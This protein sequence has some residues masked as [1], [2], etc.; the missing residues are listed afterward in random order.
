[1]SIPN[2]RSLAALVASAA[3][4]LSLG[5]ND[6]APPA[7][8]RAPA[9]EGAAVPGGAD[10]DRSRSALLGFDH[11][12]PVAAFFFLALS[13][14]IS[15]TAGGF[16][17]PLEAGDA[18]GASSAALGDLDGDGFVEVAV[19]ARG[20]GVE[21][22][23]VWI[24]SLNTDSTVRWERLITQST[25]GFGGT[26]PDYATFGRSLAA[27]GD[28]DGDGVTDLAVGASG[29]LGLPGSVWVLFLDS[30]GTVKREQEISQ[31]TGGFGGSLDGNDRFG[32]SLAALGDVDGDGSTELAVGAHLDDDGG[33][34]RGAVWLLSLGA[35]G[36]VVAERKLSSTQGGLDADLTDGYYLGISVAAPGDLNG[37]GVPDLAVGSMEETVWVLLLDRDLTIRHHQPIA[38]GTGRFH[39][40]LDLWDRFGHGLAA[41]G[42]LDGD[43]VPDLLA[44]APGDDDCGQDGGALWLLY[45]TREGAVSWSV[46]YSCSQA[47]F[48]KEPGS[49]EI[50]LGMLGDVNHDGLSEIGVGSSAEGDNQGALWVLYGLRFCDGD[51]DDVCLFGQD[52]CVEME[53]RTGV[54]DER[55][56]F[57]PLPVAQDPTGAA[58]DPIATPLTVA[59][60]APLPL[61]NQFGDDALLG[62]AVAN[63]GDVDG[64]GIL[65]VA[66]GAE[67]AGWPEAGGVVVAL[68]EAD[69]RTRE[70]QGVFEKRR[71]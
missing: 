55:C 36:T 43:G 34:N 1:M 54:A 69:G 45:L 59:E 56:P 61:G 40:P 51:D 53:C 18:F 37:D 14:E 10:L 17:G 65:D 44:T 29:R 38:A 48:R 35:D 23:G 21:A 27:L 58:C 25:G 60:E 15:S 31:G 24:L 32:S 22:G 30:D 12:D 71:S 8:P 16:Q 67:G 4:V 3:V 5:C 26:L 6:P 13:L 2:V 52:S 9:G 28:L 70:E 57:V 47:G 46:K 64:D 66:L 39:E 41:P 68:L 11:N 33:A 49:S 19:G 7:A 50:P 63:V 62:T 20:V 42:D